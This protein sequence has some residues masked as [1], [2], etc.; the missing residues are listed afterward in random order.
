VGDES[1]AAPADLAIAGV[2][3]TSYA[4]VKAA[5]AEP[6]PLDEALAA[7]ALDPAGWPDAD[8]GWTERL[9]EDATLLARYES[10]LAGAEDRLVRAVEPLDADL[11]AWVAFLAAMTAAPAPDELLAQHDLGPNDLARL[12]RR[13]ERRMKAEPAL[14]KRAAELRKKGAGRLPRVR[15]APR[16][17]QRSNSAPMP[18]PQAPSSTA[19]TAAAVETKDAA[20]L[21]EHRR[22]ATR[23]GLG[24]PIALP[25][26]PPIA[27]DADERTRVAVDLGK[28]ELPFR[29]TPSREYLEALEAPG[30]ETGDGSDGETVSL[31]GAEALRDLLLAD[32]PP[33]EP[34]V[35]RVVSGVAREALPFAAPDGETL[36]M[37]VGPRRGDVADEKTRVMPKRGEA[38]ED[39]ETVTAVAPSSAALPF[40]SMDDE[41]TEEETT[42]HRRADLALERHASL[43]LELAVDAAHADEVLAR[44][45][46]TAAEKERLDQV[47]RALFAQ[48][49]A[50]RAKWNRAFETYRA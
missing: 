45:Q 15:A 35:T 50:L 40:V 25:I 44:Y 36:K 14:E 27:L 5:L 47:Y 24:P 26:V 19:T 7:E 6:I 33:E 20:R 37:L 2:S 8:L 46:V 39:P 49:P 29:A 34:T 21:H 13:W 43:C 48:D 9:V 16:A 31:T 3:L 30:A 11:S 10:E 32:E 17:L 4:R 38:I 28:R 18:V 23:Q 42:V 12:R 22:F 41:E 1:S